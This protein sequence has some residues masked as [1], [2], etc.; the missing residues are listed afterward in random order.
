MVAVHIPC[1][2][3]FLFS[4]VFSPVPAGLF[5]FMDILKKQLNYCLYVQ[6][7]SVILRQFWGKL[8]VSP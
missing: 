8:W 2:A 4:V 1:Y 5:Y 3:L 7:S 6:D